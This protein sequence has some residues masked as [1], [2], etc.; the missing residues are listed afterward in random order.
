MSRARPSRQAA[1]LG[2][3]QVALVAENQAGQDSAVLKPSR[4]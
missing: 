1:A 4:S 3:R 2:E